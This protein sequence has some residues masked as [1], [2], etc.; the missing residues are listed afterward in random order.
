MSKSHYTLRTAIAVLLFLALS[1]RPA[2]AQDAQ[3]GADGVGDPYFPLLG[4]GGYDVQHYTIELAVDMETNTISGTTT[5][6][7]LATQNL[8]A[9]NLDF[10]GLDISEIL[11]DGE[12]ASFSRG[13]QELTIN[14]ATPL[15]DSQAFSVAVT[16]GGVPQPMPGPRPDVPTVGWAQYK[17][18]VFVHNFPDG[19]MTWFPCNNHPSDKATF[20]FRITVAKPFT[21]AANGTLSDEVD[22]G[23]TRTFIWTVQD[24]M[25]SSNAAPRIA[26]FKEYRQDGP[27]GLEI[28]NFIPPTATDDFQKY[29]VNVPDMIAYFSDTFGPYPFESF[30]FVIPADV[31]FTGGFASQSRP[32]VSLTLLNAGELPFAHELAHQ[33]WGN[34]VS[35]KTTKDTWLAEGFAHYSEYLW[36]EHKGGKFGMQ[37]WLSQQ[38]VSTPT[39][40]A[41]PTLQDFEGRAIYERGALTLH[42]L[43][44]KV[45][46]TLFFDILHTYYDRFKYSNADTAD[47]ISVAEEVSGQD[48]SDFFN[49]WL[50]STDTPPRS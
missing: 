23:D 26:E 6:D 44:Q 20:E 13:G 36:L 41:D 7:A 10:V 25:S 50:F 9:F 48:L 17:S 28:V 39:P 40:I 35:G 21:V 32:T 46:N 19:A 22:N 5:I 34:S 3:P 47:F 8:S 14:P 30:G 24:P 38:L 18:G 16:Y 43:R 49:L 15:L 33:W 11:V 31:Q 37:F 1:L 29:F 2:W 45:G 42:A 4:N 12:A 27:N